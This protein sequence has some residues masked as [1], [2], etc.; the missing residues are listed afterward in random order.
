MTSLAFDAPG[1]RLASAAGTD[2]LVEVWDLDL[3]SR[4]LSR[5]GLG[6]EPR[7]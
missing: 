3:I 4:E 7:D 5:L 2:P 6:E 1:T